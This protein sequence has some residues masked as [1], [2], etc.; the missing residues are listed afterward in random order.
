[1]YRTV[2]GKE[3]ILREIVQEYEVK[4]ASEPA[5]DE[6]ERMKELVKALFSFEEKYGGTYE[7]VISRLGDPQLTDDWTW[8]RDADE[9]RYIMK[10]I[11]GER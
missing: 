8:S 7:E 2:N 6:V 4:K 3:T 11:A 1:M 10:E 5:Y 9:W